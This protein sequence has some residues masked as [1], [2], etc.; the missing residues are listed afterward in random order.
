MRRPHDADGAPRYIHRSAVLALLWVTVGIGCQSAGLTRSTDAVDGET[1]HA[2]FESVSDSAAEATRSAKTQ[3]NETR[4]K[5][6]P[7]IYYVP[8]MGESH[9]NG[10]DGRILKTERIETTDRTS[11]PIYRLMPSPF[12]RPRY[13]SISAE[14]MKSVVNRR[15][16]MKRSFPIRLA[17]FRDAEPE[18]A[19]ADSSE[20]APF[21]GSEIEDNET[22]EGS[23]VFAPN[24]RTQFRND[25]RGFLPDV[26]NDTQAIANWHNGAWI[27]GAT[28]IAL[29]L[30]ADADDEVRQKTAEHPDRWGDGSHVLGKLG[31]MQWQV[32]AIL[33]V[34]GNSV[35][36]EDVQLYD[37][38]RSLINAY[39]ITGVSTVALKGIANTER[40]SDEWN[41]GDLGFPSFHTSSS[42]TIA[43]VVEEYYG[44]E[45]AAPLYVLA[46]LIGWSRIDERDHDLSDVVFGAMLGYIVGKSVAAYH[47]HDD[48]RVRIRPTYSQINETY[49]VIFETSY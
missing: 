32:P 36:T 42:F 25:V 19:E 26:W 15:P 39:T 29:A 3:P 47:L 21:T 41:D 14:L 5:I 27:L 9:P 23:P 44:I 16:R 38:S 49:G 30:R 31:E 4:S 2:H 7:A 22:F 18:F 46:G 10:G 12:D 43:A 48:P 24:F 28:G 20:E 6:T 35:W 8:A 37:F 33:L 45:R 17:A 34:Y 11:P 13:P 40:P 1:F